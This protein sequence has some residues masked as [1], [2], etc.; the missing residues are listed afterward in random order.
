MGGSLSAD[1]LASYQV[2]VVDDPLQVTP[3]D[4]QVYVLPGTQRRTDARNGGAGIAAHSQETGSEARRETF[5]AYAAALK[6]A[7][8]YRMKHMGDAGEKTMPT[9]TTHFSVVDQ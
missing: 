3:G 2:N 8:E 7:W 5:V 1:D 9:C 6:H 4:R